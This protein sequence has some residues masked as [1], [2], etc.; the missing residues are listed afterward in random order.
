M[1]KKSRRSWLIVPASKPTQLEEASRAGADVVVLDLFEFVPE[2]D[3][4][5]ARDAIKDAIGR[6]TGG[7]AQA[8]L[9]IGP[10]AVVSDL[11]AAVWPGLS[12]VIVSRAETPEQIETVSSALDRLERDRGIAAGSIEIVAALETAHGNHAADDVLRASPRVT[13]ATLGR[14]D[15][16]MDLRPEPSG[17]IHLMSYL[18]QRL[19]IVANAAGVTP[20]GAWWR[21]PDR[22]LLATPDN[23]Y[24]AAK[25]G[26]AIGFKGAMCLRANQV[27]ALNRGYQG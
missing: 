7:G 3:R 4:A 16:V 15:L 6:V 14:V 19:V 23:T 11:A 27:D 26:R 13:G 22:G 2:R 25:R 20:L 5:A 17:E 8:F 9:Q 10:S 12:G 21:A 24:A 1:N 18:M